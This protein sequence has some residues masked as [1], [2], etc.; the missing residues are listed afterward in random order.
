MKK[1]GALKVSVSARVDRVHLVMQPNDGFDLGMMRVTHPVLLCRCLGV[2]EYLRG[3]NG[4][5][6]ALSVDLS[7]ACPSQTILVGS[8]L[9]RLLGA[10]SRAVILFDGARL[11]VHPQTP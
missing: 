3:A 8:E 10:P 11:F 6:E 1:T 4:V 9:H 7:N 5:R 2:E